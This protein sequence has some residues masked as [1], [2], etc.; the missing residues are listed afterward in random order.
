MRAESNAV[1]RDRCDRLAAE[2]AA[3][4]L[5]GV[6]VHSWRRG[7]V[8]WFTGYDPGFV[9]N[10][11]TLWV[12]SS[13]SP[14]LG[15]RFP[16]DAERARRRSGMNVREGAAP[17][18]LVPPGAT[19][20]GVVGGDMAVD[21]LPWSAVDLLRQ[22]GTAVEDV[23][24]VVDEWRAVKSPEE[25]DRLRHAARVAHESLI[26]LEHRSLVGRT[27]FD[28]AA[29]VEFRARTRGA[30]WCRCLVG[31]GD[32]AAV[33]E[34]CGAVVLD[35]APVSVEITLVADQAC[36]HVNVT[37]AP[38]RVVDA[39]AEEACRSTRRFLLA[40]MLPGT[41]VDDV[42][43][44]GD[45]RLAEQDLLAFKEYDFGHGVGHDTPEHPR[46]VKGTGKSLVAAMVVA[47]HVAVRRPGGETAFIG[48]PVVVTASGVEELVSEAPWAR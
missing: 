41:A 14:C 44:A 10:H 21:E 42:V 7:A 46:L 39:R 2:A 13:G 23:K 3:R 25:V 26:D 22:R 19:R 45:A 17:V 18:D 24:D 8:A 29:D 38:G 20:V 4:G 6:I 31:I 28:I 33:T 9:T 36:T 43:A 15:V 12:P 16:F 48:G 47:V 11:A 40:A 35:R 34:A 27:D 5:D 32:G 1:V 37:A 30:T